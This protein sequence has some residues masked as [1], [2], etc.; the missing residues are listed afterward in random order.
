MIFLPGKNPIQKSMKKF[1][2]NSKFKKSEL[3]FDKY[4][5]KQNFHSMIN[6][7]TEKIEYSVKNV[8]F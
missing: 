1:Y 6:S 2:I 3:K 4:K 7:Y 8:L 5:D